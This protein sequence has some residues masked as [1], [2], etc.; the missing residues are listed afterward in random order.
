M[1]HP[2]QSLLLM[3]VLKWRGRCY[4]LQFFACD[5]VAPV[6][7]FR[8]EM[9]LAKTYNLHFLEAVAYNDILDISERTSLV[10]GMASIFEFHSEKVI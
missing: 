9:V 1:S 6:Y 2:F 3:D 4:L 7:K 10:P 5:S 8:R